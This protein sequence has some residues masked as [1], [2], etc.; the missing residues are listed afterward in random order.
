VAG[1]A[2]A[3]WRRTWT[4]LVRET[5]IEQQRVGELRRLLEGARTGRLESEAT[6]VPLMD[7]ADIVDLS[8]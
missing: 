2:V 1:V 5:S 4:A 6:R 8:E 3:S 7:G